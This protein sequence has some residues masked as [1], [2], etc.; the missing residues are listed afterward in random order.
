MAERVADG[1]RASGVTEEP[2]IPENVAGG[3]DVGDGGGDVGLGR[4]VD[5]G[6]GLDGEKTDVAVVEGV[7]RGRVVGRRAGG[8]RGR[9]REEGGG[10]RRG[11]EGGSVRGGGLG[12]AKGLA[13]AGGVVGSAADAAGIGRSGAAGRTSGACLGALGPVGTAAEAAKNVKDLVGGVI[14]GDSPFDGPGVGG[15]WGRRG[16]GCGSQKGSGGRCVRGKRGI[17]GGGLAD[18]GRARGEEELGLSG[19]VARNS[20]EGAGQEGG[21]EPLTAEGVQDLVREH[22]GGVV[23]WREAGLHEGHAREHRYKARE[24]GIVVL[25]GQCAV[26]RGLRELGDA[27]GAGGGLHKGV[28]DVPHVVIGEAVVVL[29][30]GGQVFLCEAENERAAYGA[31]RRGDGRG[32]AGA[33]EHGARTGEGLVVE[34]AVS[35]VWGVV[36]CDDAHGAG[37]VG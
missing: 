5:G 6:E 29:V 16:G 34:A 25:G 19:E 13:G 35:A 26:G 3:S 24:G 8:G 10:G 18:T 4:G 33:G 12:G 30:E 27:E 23:A 14:V 17:Q 20:V 21:G 32:S 11:G 31:K 22:G 1:G 2:Q 37:Y 7:G 15:G 28:E 36:L 9:A